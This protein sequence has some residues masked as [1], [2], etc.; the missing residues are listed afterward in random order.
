MYLYITFKFRNTEWVSESE[1]SL[2][3]AQPFETPWTT[4]HGILQAKILEWVAVPFSRGYSQPRDRN[5][6]SNNVGRFFTSWDTTEAQK[7]RRNF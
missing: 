7:H 3:R 1:K 2:Y 6:V 5:Q 4:V